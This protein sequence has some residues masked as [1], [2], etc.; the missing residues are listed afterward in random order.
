MTQDQERLLAVFEVRVRDLM[1]F[2]DQQKQ[3]INELL[4]SLEAKDKELQ[5]AKQAVEG[6]EAKYNSVLTARVVSASEK[7][8]KSAKKRLSVL[9]QEVE[10][11][12]ALLNSE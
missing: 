12:I 7:E 4:S 5:Q 11:C 10:K 1:A 6:L 3:Q 2:C 9:V 8:I